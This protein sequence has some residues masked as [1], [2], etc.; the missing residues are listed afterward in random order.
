MVPWLGGP[1]ALPPPPGDGSVAWATRGPAAAAP[2]MVPWLGATRGPAAAAPVMCP[3][4]GRPEALPPPP[5]VMVPWLGDQRPCRRR[6]V[7]VR[8]WAARG[9][10]AA[11][12]VD[13]S[14]AWAT[15]VRDDVAAAPGP[16]ET[17]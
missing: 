9:P 6:P 5:R 2:V 14:V 7:M 1:E 12:P 13:G 15:M 3:W 17:D 16:A 4:L 10:A 8:G 11:A